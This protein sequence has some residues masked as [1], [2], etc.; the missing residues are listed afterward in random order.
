MKRILLTVVMFAS[1]VATS[2]AQLNEGHA[3]YKV[4]VSSDEAEMAM[5]VSMMQGTTLDIYFKDQSTRSE[6]NMGALMKIETIMDGESGNALMLMDGMIGKKAIKTTAEELEAK[7]EGT[8]TP[9][10]EVTLVDEQKKIAGYKCKK[11]ILT[12]EDDNELIFWYTEDIKV[13]K[14]GQS[15]LN[16]QVP[17]FP[18]QYEINQNKMLMSFTVQEFNEKLENADEL[19]SQDIPDGYEEMTLEELR[20]MGM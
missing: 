3:S 4:D 14:K 20:M 7:S 9:D 11:A 17:G 8:E 10:F 18:M 6:V 12:D 15:Y 19:F 1:F 5:A 16:D 2:M 13:N